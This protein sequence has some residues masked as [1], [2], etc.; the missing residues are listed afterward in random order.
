VLLACGNTRENITAIAAGVAALRD[1]ITGQIFVF[2]AKK[3]SNT[4][5]LRKHKE[6]KGRLRKLFFL[7][8]LCLLCDFVLS[9]FYAAS[10]R[11]AM[12]LTM[13]PLSNHCRF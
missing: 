11:Y 8:T 13:M 4:K 9:N 10:L 3:S 6:H 7:W 5:P 1:N 2:L 12:P